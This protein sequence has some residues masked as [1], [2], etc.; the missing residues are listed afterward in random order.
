LIF[1][2]IITKKK[3]SKWIMDSGCSR[4]MS[5]KSDLFSEITERDGGT[6][7]LG[8][9]GKCKIIGIGNIGKEAS[10][11]INNVYLVDGLKFNLLSVSQLCDNGNKVVFDKEK[12][13][14]EN[15]KSGEVLLTAPRSN[16][17]YSVYSNQIAGE[18]MKCLKASNDD[19]RLWH[20][21]LGYVSMHTLNKLSSKNMIMGRPKLKFEDDNIC[22]VCAKG[23]QTRSSFKLKRVVSTSRPIE[24]LHMDLCGPMRVKS[25]RGIQYML[26]IVDDYSRFTWV[27][28]L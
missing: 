19:P 23:T 9:K 3:E 25:S 7:T 12:C 2:Q 4:H 10:Q 13:I 26:V 24:L 22:D 18:N 8:D 1:V 14:V 28:F 21:K 15:V 27:S 6:I 20:R 5:G 11:T 17:T 16:N